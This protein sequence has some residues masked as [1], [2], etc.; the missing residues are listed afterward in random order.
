MTRDGAPRIR[1]EH[2]RRRLTP[3]AF[4]VEVPRSPPGGGV[5]ARL[6]R[7]M[8][9]GRRLRGV[10]PPPPRLRAAKGRAVSGIPAVSGA[11]SVVV[12]RR[13]VRAASVA[14]DRATA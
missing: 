8:L 7:D 5:E 14:P 1:D 4:P 9:E 11:A 10:F 12:P 6:G 2:V 3:G 13:D